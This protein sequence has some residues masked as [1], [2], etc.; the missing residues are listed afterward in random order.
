MQNNWRNARPD[1]DNDEYRLFAW[2]AD[3]EGQLLAMYYNL[4]PRNV[5]GK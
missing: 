1:L 3:N 2:D 5:L 4:S